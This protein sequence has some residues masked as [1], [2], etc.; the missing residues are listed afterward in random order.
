MSVQL[1][2]NSIEAVVYVTNCEQIVSMETL[3]DIHT[4]KVS[5]AILLFVYDTKQTKPKLYR[6]RKNVW[7]SD[8]AND[9]AVYIALQSIH[10]E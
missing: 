8:K 9:R 5:N 4:D 10:A 6:F 2:R 1:A 3:I 7:I